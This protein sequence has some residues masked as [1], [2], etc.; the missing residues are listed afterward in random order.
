[1]RWL[2]VAL[3]IG[4]PR[5]AVVLPRSDGEHSLRLAMPNASV[6]LFR[7]TDIYRCA[8]VQMMPQ[9]RRMEKAM[10]DD[11]DEAVVGYD[12][13]F[14]PPQN[15]RYIHHV[16]LYACP[17]SLALKAAQSLGRHAETRCAVSRFMKGCEQLALAGTG[18][19]LPPGY[20]MHLPE[21]AVM[22]V[23]Y[24]VGRTDERRASLHDA[25]G[26]RLHLARR[27]PAMRS[28]QYFSLTLATLFQRTERAV[29]PPGRVGIDVPVACAPAC[30]AAALRLGRADSLR[31]LLA[32]LHMHTA[33]QYGLLEAVRPNGTRELLFAAGVDTPY[34]P[35]AHDFSIVRSHATV[36]SGDTLRV[37]C[38]YNTSARTSD[39][40]LPGQ[41]VQDEMC[42]AMGIISPAIDDFYECVGR[43]Q[44]AAQALGTTDG[45]GNS[46]KQTSSRWSSSSWSR[47]HQRH[48]HSRRMAEATTRSSAP[49][50]NDASS[51]RH[52]DH[53]RHATGGP[54]ASRL[55]PLAD[56]C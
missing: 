56:L 10:N 48:S 38:V 47:S 34:D 25:S 26:F 20:Y 18:I 49:D 19:R 2:L 12:F 15:Y 1:M 11:A 28:A 35:T 39:T 46:A 23:H 42:M 6:R 8:Y 36:Q 9:R 30:I 51:R 53:R 27:Q 37:T 33:G 21:V 55:K 17:R 7:G 41:N 16:T 44:P 14:D 43:A 52:R 31:V 13:L 45:H 24:S 22:E 4:L 29:L 3:L 54:T 5:A 40:K 50:N 32:Y